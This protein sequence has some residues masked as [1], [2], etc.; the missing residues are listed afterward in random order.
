MDWDMLYVDLMQAFGWT[1]EY[2]DGLNLPR[3]SEIYRGFSQRPPVHWLVA[4]F[5]GFKPKAQ[6]DG[7]QSAPKVLPSTLFSSM[8][9]GKLLDE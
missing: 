9:S 1:W 2:V 4:S 8:G 6:S 7:T 3:V 5:L